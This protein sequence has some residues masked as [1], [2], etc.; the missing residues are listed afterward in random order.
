MRYL[1]VVIDI[2][3]VAIFLRQPLARE[4][5]ARID[6]HPLVRDLYR[7]VRRLISNVETLFRQSVDTSRARCAELSGELLITLDPFIHT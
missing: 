1:R 4:P 6:T 3:L 7:I 2:E 5:Q